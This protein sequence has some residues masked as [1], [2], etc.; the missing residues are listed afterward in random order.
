VAP[1]AVGECL[2][3]IASVVVFDAHVVLE[4][5]T[6][7]SEDFRNFKILIINFARCQ[8]N[9]TLAL[10]RPTSARLLNILVPVKRCVRALNGDY[11]AWR[12]LMVDSTAGVS[13]M[14]SR[15]A[16][17]HSK[18]GLTPMSNIPWYDTQKNF[19][20]FTTAHHHQ[21]PGTTITNP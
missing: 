13:T 11:V 18:L 8:Q 19:V 4:S 1:T 2:R 17:T 9:Q 7:H 10:M 5:Y 6:L 21:S 3:Y 14:Q 15:F 12:V 20:C 16:S